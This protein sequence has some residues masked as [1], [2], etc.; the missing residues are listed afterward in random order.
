MLLRMKMR[1]V[2]WT[3]YRGHT[4]SCL[5]EWEWHLR[6][7]RQ[8]RVGVCTLLREHARHSGRRFEHLQVSLLAITIRSVP[9]GQSPISRRNATVKGRLVRLLGGLLLHPFDRVKL[10]TKRWPF[11]DGTGLFRAEENRRARSARDGA[12]SEGRLWTCCSARSERDRSRVR[13][14]LHSPDIELGRSWCF[15]RAADTRSLTSRARGGQTGILN[16]QGCRN[17]SHGGTLSLLQVVCETV[18]EHAGARA[19][20]LRCLVLES[21][22]WSSVGPCG[23]IH[24]ATTVEIRLRLW[25]H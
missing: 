23:R 4:R 19:A 7:M 10:I 16:G 25:R 14:E 22:T 8:L 12:A 24:L 6:L 3:R 5:L 18:T 13:L 9:G 17:R 21:P 2:W 11:G 20:R 15:V 1:S